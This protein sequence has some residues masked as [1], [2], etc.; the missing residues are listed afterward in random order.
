MARQILLAILGPRAYKKGI[1]KSLRW[2]IN[3][4]QRGPCFKCCHFCCKKSLGKCVPPPLRIRVRAAGTVG[5]GVRRVRTQLGW[6][7]MAS[8]KSGTVF[9]QPLAP[10][11][12]RG[13]A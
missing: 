7:S 12:A 2:F 5:A 11:L 6:A 3:L 1:R 9:L 4:S 13:Q 8:S 10:G